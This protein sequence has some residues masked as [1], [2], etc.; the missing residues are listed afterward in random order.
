[1]WGFGLVEE[2]YGLYIIVIFFLFFFSSFHVVGRRGGRQKGGGT[3]GE[4][5]GLIDWWIDW[6][7]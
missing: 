7:D 5:V 1:M 6:Y 4:K 2:E 3:R